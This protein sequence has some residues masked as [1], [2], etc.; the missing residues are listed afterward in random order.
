M[1]QYLIALM[2][3]C[4]NAHC[5]NAYCLIALMPNL[6]RLN[7]QTFLHE[8]YAHKSCVIVDVGARGG[9]NQ[10]G[11]LHKKM[12]VHSVEPEPKAAAHLS[13]LD[14]DFR[15]H[16]VYELA[17]T[18]TDG[19]VALN[20]TQQESM[21][22]TLEPDAIEFLRGFGEMKNAGTWSEGMRVGKTVRV[23]S[24]TLE[25]FCEQY[26][27]GFIDFLKLDT[28]GNELEILRSGE[29][30][31]RSGRIGVVCCEVTFFPVYQQQ[32]YFSGID[33]FL[34]SCGFR[35]VECRSYPGISDREDEFAPGTKIY[36]RPKMAPVGDAWYVFDWENS[37][38]ENVD[39]RKRSAVILAAEGYFSEAKYL[40]KGVITDEECNRLFRDLS[41]GNRE[42]G[43]KHF[44]R[45][46][47]PP[48]IQQWRAKRRR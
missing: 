25:R 41:K 1:P 42:S 38:Q 15:R 6:V 30:L 39:E 16:A 35:F 8:L 9:F 43:L 44:L 46:W 20:I 5:P 22:S 40:L 48:A 14:T 4:P 18:A 45:R 37:S 10:I 21:S 31:L 3:Y 2:P 27:Q 28:Q 11:A 23:K 36:E 13:S 12:E 7:T 17:L 24:V 32:N 26:V 29:Q 33:V 19:E 34:R 47:T